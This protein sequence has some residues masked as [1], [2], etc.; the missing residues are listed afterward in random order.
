MPLED[1]AH[2]PLPYVTVTSV[3]WLNAGRNSGGIKD[4]SISNHD[5]K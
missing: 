4:S 5:R 3:Y 1:S 2:Q